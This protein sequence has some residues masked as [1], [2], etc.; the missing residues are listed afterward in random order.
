VKNRF[1]AFAFHKRNMYRYTAGIQVDDGGIA[2]GF[3][4]VTMN[5]SIPSY[6]IVQPSAWDAMEAT[7][8]LVAAATGAVG[9]CTLN[10]VD[11]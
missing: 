11:P 1:Q 6:D 9:R 5:G 10:Q 4:V 7:E 8:A 2:T 3:V